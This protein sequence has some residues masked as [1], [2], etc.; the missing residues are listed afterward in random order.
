M[1][2]QRVLLVVAILLGVVL[3]IYAVM[4]LNRG[5]TQSSSEFPQRSEGIAFIDEAV[6]YDEFGQMTAS[7]ELVLSR[8]PADH[9]TAGPGVDLADPEP[10]P[11]TARQGSRA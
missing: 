7:A 11:A 5:E 2:R 10:E 4:L 1:P 9:Q 3:V 6:T 8:T